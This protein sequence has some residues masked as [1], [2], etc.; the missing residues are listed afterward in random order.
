[1]FGPD[2]EEVTGEW[3]ILV[4]LKG[5]DSEHVDGISVVQSIVHCRSGEC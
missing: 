5:T 4:G 1:V 3:R 2:K